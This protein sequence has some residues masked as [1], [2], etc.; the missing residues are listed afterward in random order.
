MTIFSGNKNIHMELKG[1]KEQP[2]PSL[3][4]KLMEMRSD[5]ELRVKVRWVWLKLS[6]HVTV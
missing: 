6:D 2:G 3:P 1:L 4:R 5:S